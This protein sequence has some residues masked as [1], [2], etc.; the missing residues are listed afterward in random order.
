ME[1]EKRLVLYLPYITS[2][3]RSYEGDHLESI[4]PTGIHGL[5]KIL[6]GGSAEPNI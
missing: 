2:I 5:D 1:W 4:V 6:S 3:L